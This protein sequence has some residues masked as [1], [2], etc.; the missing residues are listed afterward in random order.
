[1]NDELNMAFVDG[2]LN[3]TVSGGAEGNGWNLLDDPAL[4][5]EEE[6]EEEEQPGPSH[7]LELSEKELKG[8]SAKNL[9]SAQSSIKP[10]GKPISTATYQQQRPADDDDDDLIDLLG[11]KPVKK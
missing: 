1:M 5:R 2:E 9:L 6:E 11:I 10:Q 7:F 4:L 8:H 3:K